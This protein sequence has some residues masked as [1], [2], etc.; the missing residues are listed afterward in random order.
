MMLVMCTYKGIPT[1]DNDKNKVRRS[2][3]AR[4]IDVAEERKM[5]RVVQMQ[6]IRYHLWWS[7]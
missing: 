7:N 4:R 1:Y 2:N 6:I 3:N 5:V